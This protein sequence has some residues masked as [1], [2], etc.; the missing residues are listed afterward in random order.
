MQG[1][2]GFEGW[3]PVRLPWKQAAYSISVNPRAV[4]VRPNWFQVGL[5]RA[6]EKT[7]MC[8]PMGAVPG[9]GEAFG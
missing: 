7:A 3:V 2:V 6:N 9:F 5:L 1:P 4:N 8:P